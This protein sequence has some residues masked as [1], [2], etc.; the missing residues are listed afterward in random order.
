MATPILLAALG[1]LL[2]EQSGVL[3]IGIEGA[4]LAG[5]FF[6]LAAAYFSG[7]LAA[8]LLA[9]VGAAVVINALLAMLI[10]NLAVNQVVAGTALDI[11]AAGLTGVFNRRL[12]GLTGTVHTV[13]PIPQIGLG[14]L[15]RIPLIGPSLFGQNAVVYAAFML[16]PLTAFIIRHTRYGLCIRAAGERP[17]AADAL[18]LNVYRLRWQ[19][20][21]IAGALTGLAG[22]YLTLAYTNTFVEGISAGRGFVALSVVIVGRWNA[23][24]VA[25][26]SLL[27]G[28][29]MGL[30][31]V[32]QAS[33]AA[34]PYQLFLALP[35]ALTVVVLAIVGG[36]AQAPSALGERY[37]RP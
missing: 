28:A 11:L 3:N 14:P 25:A 35:Y 34:L 13:A 19:T 9:A 6:G 4:M 12:F 1:E 30:Q 26:A 21:L 10:V 27:F 24:G 36:Q 20:L 5:A 22:A 23:Y 17:E 37:V 31:F 15:A 18:G 8:G 29:A 16:V 2:V 32:L 33:S 7:S